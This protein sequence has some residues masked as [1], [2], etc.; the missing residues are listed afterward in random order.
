MWVAKRRSIQD[1]WTG[2]LTAFLGLSN[3]GSIFLPKTGFRLLRNGKDVPAQCAHNDFPVDENQKSSP[4]YFQIATGGD[5]AFIWV[6]PGSHRLVHLQNEKKNY[7][8]HIFHMDQV[9]IPPYSLFFGDGYAQH[10]GAEWTGNPCLR[11][12]TYLVPENILLPDAINF[13]LNGSMPCSTVRHPNAKLSINVVQRTC[14]SPTPH[15][16]DQLE[17]E[18]ETVMG[19]N[20]AGDIP[21]M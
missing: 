20:V 8:N 7:L 17:R 10:A 15:E 1:V 4:G 11:L 9:E 14:D 18:R 21:E 3:S 6:W 19:Q 16:R 12:H 13:G 2:I 5:R